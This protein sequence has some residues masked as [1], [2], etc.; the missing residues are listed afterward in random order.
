MTIWRVKERVLVSAG[1]R[2]E[3]CALYNLH[4]V[5][6]TASG[7]LYISHFNRIP[8]CI[9]FLSSLRIVKIYRRISLSMR[10]I[11]SILCAPGMVTSVVCFLLLPKLTNFRMHLMFMKVFDGS[12]W[13]YRRLSLSRDSLTWLISVLLEVV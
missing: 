5:S 10:C 13:L 12:V 1:Y 3:V 7:D 6:F 4:Q 2:S 11:L 9:C 8:Y